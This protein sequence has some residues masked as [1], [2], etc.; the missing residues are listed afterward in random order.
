MRYPVCCLWY[1]FVLLF[2]WIKSR[3]LCYTKI[4]FILKAT[5][6][7]NFKWQTTKK[8]EILEMSTYFCFLDLFTFGGSLAGS[9][10]SPTKMGW[11][12]LKITFDTA[13]FLSNKSILLRNSDVTLDISAH[14]W[15]LPKNSIRASLLLR[16]NRV[17]ETPFPCT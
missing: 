8:N 12:F 9:L 4:G 6:C 5:F 14:F 7:T 2:I 11:Y 3:T 15:A 1:V 17:R 10:K 16:S 13:K